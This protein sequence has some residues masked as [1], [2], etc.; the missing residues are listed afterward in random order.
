MQEEQE[1]FGHS[2]QDVL[3]HV[4]DGVSA[5]LSLGCGFGQMEKTLVDKGC[6]VVGIELSPEAAAIASSNGLEVIAKPADVGIKD[7]EGRQ[8]DCVL[9]SDVLEHLTDPVSIFKSCVDLLAPGG[10]VVV[11][12]PNFRHISVF[13][14]IFIK[15]IVPDVEAGIFDR[16]HLRITTRKLIE[17]WFADNNINPKNCHY[18]LP[19]RLQR[20]GSFLSFGLLNEIISKQVV[21]SGTKA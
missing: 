5:I 10:T 19:G 6:S 11:S 8:F 18:N 1:Y 15:G 13:H 4:P 14:A 7:L 9:L 21:L 3:A 20:A 12:I 2:R 16:T 17:K